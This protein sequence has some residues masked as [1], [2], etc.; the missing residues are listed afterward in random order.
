MVNKGRIHGE[1]GNFLGI[2]KIRSNRMRNW[3][4]KLGISINSEKDSKK[5]HG[6]KNHSI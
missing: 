5:L 6:I 4:E 2:F 1:L 3:G